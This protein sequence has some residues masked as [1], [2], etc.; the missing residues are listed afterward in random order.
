MFQYSKAKLVSK[1]LILS[2]FILISSY[3]LTASSQN[4]NFKDSSSTYLP[5]GSFREQGNPF[6]AFRNFD[7][8]KI[9]IKQSNTPAV[10]AMDENVTLLE[11]THGNCFY[12]ITFNFLTN[13]IE[14]KHAH[15]Y[16]FDVNLQPIASI[17]YD[18]NV[19]LEQEFNANGQSAVAAVIV[20]RDPSEPR[21]F[22]GFALPKYVNTYSWQVKICNEG[23]CASTGAKRINYQ[24]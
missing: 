10:T 9:E 5:K 24:P 11:C 14:P 7:F 22:R 18:N 3:Y 23:Q 21:Q 15:L 12:G 6:N 8:S 20:A 19:H 13:G 16:I 1:V 2:I 4:K 17:F